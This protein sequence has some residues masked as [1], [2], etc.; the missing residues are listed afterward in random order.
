VYA[1]AEDDEATT[2]VR[3]ADQQL[4]ALHACLLGLT[5]EQARSTPCRSA[6]SPAGIVKHVTRVMSRTVETLTRGPDGTAELDYAAHEASF[7]LTDDETAAVVLAQFEAVRP[8]Y[9]AALGA[10]DPDG[11]THAPP[12]PWDGIDDERPVRHRFLLLHQVEE[13]ARH[14]GHADIVREQVDGLALPALVMTEEGRPAN[15]FFEPYLPAPGTIGA[16]DEPRQSTGRDIERH[17]LAASSPS[18]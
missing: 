4:A 13:L 16:E 17:A 9:L 10:T 7:V 12:A 2:I 14:A 1:P 15:A 18:G 11:R 3:Y 5:E 8:A 6:L